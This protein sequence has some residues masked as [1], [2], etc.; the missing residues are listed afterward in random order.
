MIYSGSW[1]SNTFIM[2][3]APVL[4]NL[5][6]GRSGVSHFCC[7]PL[8]R[9]FL[10]RGQDLLLTF[11]S[12][13]YLEPVHPRNLYRCFTQTDTC[14]KKIPLIHLSIKASHNNGPHS[15]TLPAKFPSILSFFSHCKKQKTKKLL[16]LFYR[17]L[18]PK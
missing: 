4:L 6:T 9:H 12:P 10:K 3:E 13:F 16:A 15:Q 14:L 11:F 5:L 7:C 2:S 1:S 17:R 8:N 18:T